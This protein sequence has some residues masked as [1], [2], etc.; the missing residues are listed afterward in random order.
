MELRIMSPDFDLTLGGASLSIVWGSEETF[1]GGSFEHLSRCRWWTPFLGRRKRRWAC[2]FSHCFHLWQNQIRSGQWVD[3]I[4]DVMI[5]M[6]FELW[7]DTDFLC[8]R[9]VSALPS[10]DTIGGGKQWWKFLRIEGRVENATQ[11]WGDWWCQQCWQF[12][13]NGGALW[14]RGTGR[15]R[16]KFRTLSKGLTHVWRSSY[17][18]DFSP[19][20]L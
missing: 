1:C 8:L 2:R 11:F 3:L 18:S 9:S 20:P 7:S 12:R 4:D 5:Q 15:M 19:R 6:M 16:M 10:F 13:N 17:F 14:R